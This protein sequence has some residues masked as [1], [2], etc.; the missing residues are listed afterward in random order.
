ME[1]K[2]NQCRHFQENKAF[3][4]TYANRHV[5]HRDVLQG[6]IRYSKNIIEELDNLNFNSRSNRHLIKSKSIL[7]CNISLTEILY[8]T[9][10]MTG[11][12]YW[13]VLYI[14]LW[15]KMLWKY[16]I[17]PKKNYLEDCF[18]KCF[19]LLFSLFNFV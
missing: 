2:I 5:H 13:K 1:W 12:F 15:E 18:Y 10:W 11:W 16:V 17:H 6:S 9:G 7:Y 3:H 8:A 14:F 4:E 19:I